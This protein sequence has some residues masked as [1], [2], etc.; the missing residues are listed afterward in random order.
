MS[1]ACVGPWREEGGDRARAQ[2][3]HSLPCSAGAAP[4]SLNTPSLLSRLGHAS[5]RFPQTLLHEES[6]PLREHLGCPTF[7]GQSCLVSSEEQLTCTCLGCS[8]CLLSGWP[9]PV[10]D[11]ALLRWPSCDWRRG[12]SHV[13]PLPSPAAQA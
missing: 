7:S 1:A 11:S 8:L 13:A 6:G 12:P 10:P 5:Q 2:G 4:T 9:W 3:S